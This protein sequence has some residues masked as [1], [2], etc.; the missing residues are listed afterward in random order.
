MSRVSFIVNTDFL[1]R[2]ST[3]GVLDAAFRPSTFKLA[4]G[5]G[6]TPTESQP[7]LVGAVVYEGAVTTSEFDDGTTDLLVSIPPEAGP[8]EYGEIGLFL[9]DGTLIAVY[10]YPTLNVKEQNSTSGVNATVSVHCLMKLAP[11]TATITITDSPTALVPLVTSWAAVSDPPTMNAD[12]VIVSTGQGPIGSLKRSS[13]SQWSPD[14][15][16]V[17]GTGLLVSNVATVGADTVLS[18]TGV[19]TVVLSVLHRYI[20]QSSTGKV[21]RARS[22][23]AAGLLTMEGL[24]PWVVN[25]MTVTLWE[26]TSARVE[27][28]LLASDPH[29]QYLTPAEGGAQYAPI[30]HVSAS[31]AHAQ[32]LLKTEA[33]TQYAPLSHTTAPDPHP[34]YLLESDAISGYLSR[35]VNT[36]IADASG[37]SRFRFNSPSGVPGVT[38]LFGAPDTGGVVFNFQEQS[39]GGSLRSLMR[40]YSD[41]HVELPQSAVSID[42]LDSSLATTSWVASRLRVP[43]THTMSSGG[44]GITL[45]GFN[46][47]VSYDYTGLALDAYVG[48]VENAVYEASLVVT[49]PAGSSHLMYL[50]PNNAQSYVGSFQS[51]GYFTSTGRFTLSGA[52]F[53]LDFRTSTGCAQY[54]AQFQIHNFR[55]SGKSLNIQGSSAQGSLVSG[56]TWIGNPTVQWGTLGRFSFVWGSQPAASAVN[57][58][59]RLKRI[60]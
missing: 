31:N 49:L 39:A 30:S 12:V 33:A 52:T 48:I 15:H 59:L 25:G 42:T 11:G 45:D 24:A 6:Y 17:V 1:G 54:T 20:I 35:A 3:H 38:E 21:A 51:S 5:F 14:D 60:A 43:K 23:S 18:V 4:S 16:V 34:Q 57:W 44:T 27:A 58:K 37:Q 47:V 7:G 55:A 53:Y 36:L 10:A 9:D 41:G 50:A 19:D 2:L 56:S 46:E 40:T 32:Y 28:H 8:F 13:A 29:P 22:V 26:R